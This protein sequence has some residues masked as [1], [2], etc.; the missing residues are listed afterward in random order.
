MKTARMPEIGRVK[1]SPWWRDCLVVC[2]EVVGAGVGRLLCRGW[3]GKSTPEP[4]DLLCRLEGLLE[5]VGM[6]D[7]SGLQVMI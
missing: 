7:V 3:L 4:R 2:L 1:V 5:S 6:G